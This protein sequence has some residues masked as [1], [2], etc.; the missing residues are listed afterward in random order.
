M[1]GE[2]GG[3]KSLILKENKSAHYVHCFAHQLQLTLV[4]TAKNHV[5]VIWIFDFVSD[6]I[7]V[8]GSSCKRRDILR[9]MRAMRLAEAINNGE[10]KTGKWLN[11]ELGLKRPD[12]L[13]ITNELSLALQRE[14]QDMINAMHLVETSMKCLQLLRDDEFEDLLEKVYQYCYGHDIDIPKMD[15]IYVTPGISK[16]RTPTNQ[17]CTSLIVLQL[18]ELNTRFNELNTELLLCVACLRHQDSFHTF[19]VTKLVR[20]AEF[21]PNEFYLGDARA[22]SSELI[23]YITDGR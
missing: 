16:R 8:I 17:F 11:Q 19:D 7:N 13:G 20:M 14:D 21:Y 1:R 9:E 5:D 23:N 12:I 3:L 15:D 4:G 6:I 10:I 18:Q 22:L 2:F